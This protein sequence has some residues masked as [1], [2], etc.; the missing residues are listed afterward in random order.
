MKG[1]LANWL[2]VGANIGILAGLVMV[3]L[4]MQ[5]NEDLLRMQL[6]NEIYDS[7]ITSDLAIGGDDMYKILQKSIDAPE[8]LDYGEMRALESHTYSPLNRWI[9][10]YRLSEAGL[11]DSDLWR[12]QVAVDAPYVFG[13]PYSL[14]WWQVS[15]DTIPE[16]VLP[17][18]LR[19]YIDQSLEKPG[20]DVFTRYYDA[21]Q[22]RVR[23]NQATADAP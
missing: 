20:P 2:Q 1:T 11:L 23:E 9:N 7:Y 14:A 10:L 18:E 21:I 15:R 22:Q 17:K 16:D 13:S 12:A 6:T 4:Q 8:E 19:E 3:A 5:Q